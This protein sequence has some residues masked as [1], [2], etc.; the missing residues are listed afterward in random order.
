MLGDPRDAE[1]VAQDALVR[2]YR[3]LAAT[4]PSGSASCG[5]G[6]GW[7]RSSPTCPQPA[8]PPPSA[9]TAAEPARSRS[10]CEPAADD[11]TDPE[12]LAGRQR[13]SRRAGRAILALPERYRMPIVLRHVDGLSYAEIAAALD[14]PEGTVKAQVH[15]GLAMLRTR[16]TL[17]AHELPRR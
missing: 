17:T 11:T 9:T 7:R 14:R 4:S 6:P 1:E 5:S 12:T 2:A 10:G 15:R 16:S 8:P 13:R 3:A